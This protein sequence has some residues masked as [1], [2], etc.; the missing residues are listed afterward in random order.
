ML[1]S[2]VLLLTVECDVEDV[3]NFKKLALVTGSESKLLLFHMK[4]CATT[5]PDQEPNVSTASLFLYNTFCIASPF[6]TLNM[7]HD[8]IGFYS[9][10]KITS[11]PV[12]CIT[13]YKIK[14]NLVKNPSSSDSL[15]PIPVRPA[16]IL[17]GTENTLIVKRAL[18]FQQSTGLIT[19][20]KDQTY[21]L[22]NGTVVGEAS[23]T[24]KLPICSLKLSFF[25]HSLDSV[26]N[27]AF[28]NK[29]ARSVHM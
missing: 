11:T 28:K 17:R 15:I 13:A 19:G 12:F 2:F 8:H 9:S 1:H 24:A 20:Y 5:Y 6:S 4:Y 21:G 10:V 18:V 22:L 25:L 27:C 29:T 26:S 3:V 14:L 23:V 7:L 16:S